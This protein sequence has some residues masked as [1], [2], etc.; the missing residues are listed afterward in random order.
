MWEGVPEGQLGRGEAKERGQVRPKRAVLRIRDVLRER[1]EIDGGVPS[2]SGGYVDCLGGSARRE[3]RRN[4]RP[5][6]S[7]SSLAG[8][9]GQTGRSLGGLQIRGRQV[10]GVRSACVIPSPSSTLVGRAGRPG[11]TSGDSRSPGPKLAPVRTMRSTPTRTAS[12]YD[13]NSADRQRAGRVPLPPSDGGGI[14]ASGSAAAAAEDEGV[15]T[16]RSGRRKGGSEGRR[17]IDGRRRRRRRRREVSEGPRRP[18]AQLLS[19]RA[20]NLHRPAWS[21]ASNLHRPVCA[22]AL[23]LRRPPSSPHPSSRS[24]THLHVR[25]PPLGSRRSR[26][27]VAARC[28]LDQIGRDNVQLDA[29]QQQQQQRRARRPRRPVLLVLALVLVRVELAAADD[30]DDDDDDSLAGAFSDPR[31]VPR[32]VDRAHAP[33]GA[34]PKAAPAGG[35]PPPAARADRA[36]RQGARRP[37]PPALGLLPEQ[38]DDDSAPQ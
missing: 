35:A 15:W 26:P 12:A 38:D 27:P 16:V 3:R 17:I 21:E 13:R 22:R 2:V 9:D 1:A 6:C 11:E 32:P 19:G 20:S 5:A 29:R 37:R 7:G 34:P 25:P 30:N 14:S 18:G 10:R 33:A 23:P 24:P 8:G 31:R 36:R 28:R 4:G